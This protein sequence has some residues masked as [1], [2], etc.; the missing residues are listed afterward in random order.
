MATSGSTQ[1]SQSVA[2]AAKDPTP[3]AIQNL[4]Y[5]QIGTESIKKSNDFVVETADGGAEGSINPLPDLSD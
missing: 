5:E 2:S 3:Q 1:Y 4:L